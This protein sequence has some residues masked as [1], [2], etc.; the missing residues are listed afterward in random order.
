M[1]EPTLK[2]KNLT[3]M[4]EIFKSQILL[5]NEV[6]V[7]NKNLG[8]SSIEIFLNK[9]AMLGEAMDCVLASMLEC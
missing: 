1:M 9:L 8:S 7:V 4:E 5:G 3:G 2:M 6:T